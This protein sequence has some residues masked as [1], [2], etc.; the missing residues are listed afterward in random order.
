MSESDPTGKGQQIPPAQDQWQDQVVAD[1]I[2][3]TKGLVSILDSLSDGFR[4]RGRE[5]E[6]LRQRLAILQSERRTV[7]E[8]RS[9]LEAEI[10]SLTTD[11]D[12][13]GSRLEG[14]ERE[15]EQ[16][17]QDLAR[18]QAGL[19]ART[20]EIQDLQAAV[21]DSTRK[22]EELQ[23]IV[24]G[25][26][27]FLVSSRRELA[28]SQQLIES[29]RASLDEE[30]S[31]T[32]LLQ[33]RMRSQAQDL[34]V[35]DERLEAYRGTLAEIAG[36][37]GGPPDLPGSGPEAG[38]E[39]AQWG[40]LVRAVRHQA[41]I[42]TQ[43][44]EIAA[45]AQEEIAA[46]KPL[47]ESVREVLGTTEALPERLRKLVSERTMLQ[48]R[49]EQFS[50]QWHRLRQEQAQSVQREQALRQEHERLS[51]NVADLTAE[52]EAQ[53]AEAETLH[54]DLAEARERRPEE[55]HPEI[56]GL[57]EALR[58]YLATLAEINGIVGGPPPLAGG[59][60]GTSRDAAQWGELVQTVKRQ[61][62]M[63]AQ[64]QEEVVALR[65]LLQSAREV[66]GATDALPERLRELAAERAMLERRL[67]HV[68]VQAQRLQQA[69]AESTQ[70]ER[71][72]REEQERLSAQVA[73]L[74]AEL[75][76]QRI[77]AEDIRPAQA[78]ES[79]YRVEPEPVEV[80]PEARMAE[81]E[82]DVQEA[83]AEFQP[84]E[85]AELMPRALEPTTDAA[86][87][88]IEPLEIEAA[89][90]PAAGE[91][92]SE[93][94]QPADESRSWDMVFSALWETPAETAP[95]AE[96]SAGPEESAPSGREAD[97]P[98]H[99]PAPLTVE[100]TVAAFGGEPQVV[101]QGT[102]VEINE[103]GMVA[104]FEKNVPVGRVVIIR[105]RKGDEE[106]LVPGSVVRVQASEPMPGAPPTFDHLIRF[107][108]PKPDTAQRL[109][110]FLP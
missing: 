7:L 1:T 86:E 6:E 15:G 22:A 41:E 89:T 69:H 39:A 102:P 92:P 107:E 31:R 96:D 9:G 99:Q 94:A 51:Q 24:Q 90:A 47:A 42:A 84:L 48:Q 20:R 85:P 103:I 21:A 78:D 88:E 55:K 87:P 61:T 76:S 67:Q 33:E 8:E 62:E 5:L 77:Q 56:A 50:V 70:R 74:T 43:A 60:V 35:L 13:L 12:A 34:S 106:F 91:L 101:L 93:P 95:P 4:R 16:L 63:A 19:E 36:L 82:L 10:R 29:L 3:Y 38:Q 83:A 72:L 53:R 66:L 25:S 37:V 105:L 97:L 71:Q 32:A 26:E 27:E 80:I 46:L 81:P 28:S 14:R 52:L 110:A 58:T 17:R 49:L 44:Q 100:C 45:Q 23:K 30:R 109:K 73:A 65:P 75:E 68:Y 57:D 98:T 64:L 11:R 59:A 40:E 2:G 54:R 79:G 108:H 104:V 18:V